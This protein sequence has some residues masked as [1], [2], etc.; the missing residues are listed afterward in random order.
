METAS[1]RRENN[2]NRWTEFLSLAAEFGAG[3]KEA[4]PLSP[5]QTTQQKACGKRTSDDTSVFFGTSAK[6]AKLTSSSL[7]TAI[8]VA[9]DTALAGPGSL[10]PVSDL[11]SAAALLQPDKARQLRLSRALSA[12][13]TTQQQML[14]DLIS[15]EMNLCAAVAA[16]RADPPGTTRKV[17]PSSTSTSTFH[18]SST[19]SSSTFSDDFHVACL[20]LGDEFLPGD[21]GL[22][23]DC[24]KS[25]CREIGYPNRGS[26]PFPSRKNAVAAWCQALDI[27]EPKR[28]AQIKHNPSRY[29]V[30][31]WH[32][33]EKSRKR[34]KGNRGFM[35]MVDKG[36]LPDASLQ[37]FVNHTLSTR[38]RSATAAPTRK[39]LGRMVALHNYWAQVRRS[40]TLEP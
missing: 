14:T 25:L 37:S 24:G 29:R 11:T 17:S 23:C 39:S 6:K 30:A 5:Q 16:A 34:T 19:T 26:V 36:S 32:F 27:T 15:S 35:M 18:S 8:T 1:I 9:D 12:P 33:R 20:D 21:T 31:Y 13:R 38:K 22:L 3:N 40:P 4:S 7:S 10:L 2:E 28:L